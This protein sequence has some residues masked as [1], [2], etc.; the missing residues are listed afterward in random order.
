MRLRIAIGTVGVLLGLFGVFRLL[1]QVAVSDLI[2][3]FVWLAAAVILHDGVIAPITAAVGWV[4]ERAVPPRAR[5]A[6]AYGLT[7]AVGVTVIA[8]PEIHRRG[9]QA[10]S[11]ALLQQNYTGNLA[12]AL[13]VVAALALLTYGVSVLRDSA[14]R[15]RSNPSPSTANVRPSDDQVS[16]SE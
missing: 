4:L 12:I 10:P 2:V 11:K 6:L 13:G 5:R 3:L 9:S 15:N 14:T 7:A 16:S 8:L 1:T